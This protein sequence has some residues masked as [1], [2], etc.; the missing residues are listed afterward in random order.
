MGKIIKSLYKKEMLDILRDKKTILVMILIP[1]VVYPLLFFGTMMIATQVLSNQETATYRIAFEQI[2]AKEEIQS[3]MAEEEEKMGYLFEMVEVKD[4][5]QALQQG[6]IDAYLT[7]S[8]KNGQIA[9]E[10][11]YLSTGSASSTAADHMMTVLEDYREQLRMDAVEQAG[12]DITTVLYPITA[13]QT[14]HASN[15][16][17]FGQLLGA[18]LPFLLVVSIL[19]GAIYPAIDATAGEKE[20]GTLETLLTLPVSNM[21][22]IFSKFLAVSTVASVSALLNFISVGIFGTY[23]YQTMGIGGARKFSIDLAGFVPALLVML[24][25]ILAFAM[26]MSALCLCICIFAKSFKEAQ[27]YVSPLMIVVMLVSYIGFLPDLSLDS[28]YAVV[29]I[30]NIVLLVKNIFSFHYTFGN[31]F[32]VLLTNVVY[33]FLSVILMSRLYDTESMLFG[34]GGSL[35]LFERRANMK[36]GQMP[37][38]GD[39]VLAMAIA[40]LLIF[41]VQGIAVAKLGLAG[42]GVQQLCFLVLVIGFAWYIKADQKKLFSLGRP[43]GRHILGALLLWAGTYLFAILLSVPLARLFPSS[44]S[45]ME[46]MTV[47]LESQPLWMLVLVV[48]VAPAICEEMLFRGFLFGTMKEKWKPWI[49]ILVSG[50]LFGVYHMSL[51]KT[52]TVSLLGI[53]FAYVVYVSDSILCSVLM[54][55][56]N[57][58]LAVLHMANPIALKRVLPFLFA[59]KL[60]VTLVVE[61]SIAGFFLCLGGWLLVREWGIST[62]LAKK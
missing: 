8:E 56:C 44:A 54:H 32:L 21:Q 13:T 25:C 26:F 48:A 18:I 6:K 31:L 45:Q 59:E 46:Q 10:I 51:V 33:S 35:K 22:L 11:Q 4:A 28:T 7:Q 57:N 39:A 17:N 55:L 40:I 24:L 49:A 37:G 43:K 3:V 12:M 15:E 34:E 9:Y 52:V 53:V 60:S 47:W 16:E 27:N 42:V 14:D 1:L 29:P 30:A 2:D 41:Y 19:M 61:M 5:G 36:K 58:G 62:K 23:M 38:M 20:R 50:I